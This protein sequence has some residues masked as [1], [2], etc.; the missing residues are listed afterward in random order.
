MTL[1]QKT[2]MGHE[3]SFEEASELFD[4]IMAGELTEAEIAAVLVAMRLRGE[5]PD[6]IAGAANAMNKKKIR[7]DKGD[8]IVIDTCG[9]GGDGKSTINVS[10]A[11]S[12]VLAAAGVNIVKHGNVAQSGKVGSAD[13]LRHLGVPIE[14][15]EGKDSEY[16][17]KHGY[18]FL[19]APKFH[20]AMKYAGPVRRA[21]KVPTVFNFLGPLSNPCDPDYQL[22]G[23]SNID[24]LEKLAKAMEKLG[25]TGVILYSSEDGYDEVSSSAPTLCY[26]ITS[27]GVEKFSVNPADFFTP[28]EM[29]VVTDGEDAKSKFLRAIAGED[30]QLT[31]LIAL[32]TA[33]AF[34]VS[35]ICADMKDGFEKAK[36]VIKSGKVVEK[37]ESLRG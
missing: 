37:L 11:V 18:V 23:I 19:F 14:F 17:E 3:L 10:T 13:I 31:D 15:D 34:Y 33:L 20:P 35:G 12:L 32:N 26:R 5:T 36:S 1:V 21:I 25:R 16:F 29:P 2:A 27:G 30:E 24:K 7:L 4:A 22:I 28:F 6:E 8:R 9:T